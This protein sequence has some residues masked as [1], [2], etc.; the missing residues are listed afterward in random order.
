MNPDVLQSCDAEHKYK[1]M[2][3]GPAYPISSLDSTL[4]PP[5]L[6]LLTL[7]C[8][9]SMDQI[10]KVVLAGAIMPHQDAKQQGLLD[11]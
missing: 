2:R 10:L 9:A 6:E 7:T 8:P 3:H 1:V 11:L 5:A 4:R